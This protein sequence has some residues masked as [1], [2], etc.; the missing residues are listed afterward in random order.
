MAAPIA[1]KS[2][3]I[4]KVANLEGCFCVEE[5][6]RIWQSFNTMNAVELRWIDH[7]TGSEEWRALSL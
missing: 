1:V 3:Q 6:G 5:Q 4:R 2:A 7:L